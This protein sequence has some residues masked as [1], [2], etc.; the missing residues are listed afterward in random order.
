MVSVL[1]L[2]RCARPAYASIMR[3]FANCQPR[4]A[5]PR[6]TLTHDER[7]EG[8]HEEPDSQNGE[9]VPCDFLLLHAEVAPSCSRLSEDL[10]VGRRGRSSTALCA[11]VVQGVG[12]GSEGDGGADKVDD[13]EG[14]VWRFLVRVNVRFCNLGSREA[15]RAVTGE[16]VVRG[17]HAIC[18]PACLPACLLRWE[19]QEG[20][21]GAS[22]RGSGV[23]GRRR[24]ARAAAH[25]SKATRNSA[26]IRRTE[27]Q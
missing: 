13:A 16:Q 27:K 10:A 23:S 4:P 21:Q 25:V 2:L 1:R 7:E 24:E 22:S 5:A 9:A 26:E 3:S 17:C 8:Q 19:E 12:E 6:R 15:V 14:I 11:D 20:M 18:L